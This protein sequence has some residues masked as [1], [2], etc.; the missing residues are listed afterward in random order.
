MAL[1]RKKG[2]SVLL[3]VAVVLVGTLVAAPAASAWVVTMNANPSFKRTYHWE[4]EKSVSQPSVTLAVGENTQ[5]TYSVTVKSTGFTDSDWGVSGNVHMTSG[6]DD[7]TVATL[8]VKIQPD[9]LAA[10]LGCVPP[11]PFNLGGGTLDC[12]YSASLPNGNPRTAEMRATTTDGGA[13]F[14]QTPFSF[15][16]AAITEIDECV[17][18]TDSQAGNLGTVCVGDAPKTFT[19]TKTIGPFSEC[20]P[21]TVDNTARFTTNDTGATGSAS[22][23][24]GIIVPCVPL[25]ACHETVNPAGNPAVGD[26]GFPDDP[27]GGDAVPGGTSTK[28]GTNGNGPINPDGFYLV[29]GL[30][31]SDTTPIPYPGGGFVWPANTTV[32]YTEWGNSN[33]RIT[34]R[35]GGPNSVIE[36]HVQAPGDMY[37]NAPKGAAGAI[38]CGVPPPPF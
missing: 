30:L 14:V 7:I 16:N 28:P 11:L 13:R 26:N 18:V 12:G 1:R 10:T 4:I 37:A 22:A 36:W 24:V 31:F 20:G 17:A 33:I 38:F 15:T 5:V 34:S 3:L 29:G 21:R 35:I 25:G 8:G 2:V 32:K 23:S 6:D 9:D 27:F 19:Y